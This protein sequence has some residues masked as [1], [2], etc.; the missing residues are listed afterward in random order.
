MFASGNVTE[1]SSRLAVVVV[2]VVGAR[3]AGR[4]VRHGNE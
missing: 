3:M 4:R 1:F 2:V